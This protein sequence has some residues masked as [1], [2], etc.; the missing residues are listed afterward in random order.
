VRQEVCN[1]WAR[2]TAETVFDDGAE[3]WSHYEITAQVRRPRGPELVFTVPA[4]DFAALGW[5]DTHLGALA[6]VA[7][8]AG[9]RLVCAAVKERGIAAGTVRRREV[10][11]H[12]GWRKVGEALGLPH[13]QRGARRRRHGR[14][15]RGAAARPARAAS[16][17]RP[18]PTPRRR[19]GPAW[20]CCS[21]PRRTSRRRSGPRSGAPCSATATA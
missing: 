18:A 21:S 19:C 8:G 17:S 10:F 2:I 14:G 3:R 15:R 20:G 16:G 11:C 12:L 7:A 4:A 1:F 5:V 9:N 13:R 6:V